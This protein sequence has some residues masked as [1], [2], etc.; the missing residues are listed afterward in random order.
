MLKNICRSSNFVRQTTQNKSVN[1]VSAQNIIVSSSSGFLFT[2][3]QQ[4]S[5]TSSTARCFHAISA[6][7]INTN[8]VTLKRSKSQTHFT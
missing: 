5:T 3:A 8:V 7:T 1:T 6:S 2:S 4:G